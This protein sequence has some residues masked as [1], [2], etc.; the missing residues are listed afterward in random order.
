M[1]LLTYLLLGLNHRIA[2]RRSSIAVIVSKFQGDADAT[3]PGFQ[4]SRTTV[5]SSAAFTRAGNE[6][7]FSANN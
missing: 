1:D 4:A 2:L 3:D 7:V 5:L 6:V